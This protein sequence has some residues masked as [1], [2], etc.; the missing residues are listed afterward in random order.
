MG[1]IS[2][3]WHIVYFIVFW[4]A[5]S[6]RLPAKVSDM[7]GSAGLYWS[8]LFV[9]QIFIIIQCSATIGTDSY[10]PYKDEKLTKVRED[11]SRYLNIQRVDPD[12]V[13]R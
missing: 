12:E 3:I 7:S 9:N 8:E 11:I 10:I 13:P 6:S 1:V 5:P 2:L 4:S